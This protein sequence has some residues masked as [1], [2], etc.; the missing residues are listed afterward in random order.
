MQDEHRTEGAESRTE[1]SE[2]VWLT[3]KEVTARTGLHS[4]T[5]WRASRQGSLRV[6][7]TPRAPRFHVNDVDEFMRHAR[8]G[9][10]EL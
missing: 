2:R 7:G 9:L 10:A 6:G 8:S 3:Y 5:L 1:R 4:S